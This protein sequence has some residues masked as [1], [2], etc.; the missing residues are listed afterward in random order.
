VTID[1]TTYTLG[2]DP[3]LTA[4]GDNWA[5]TIPSALADGVYEVTV[6]ATDGLGDSISDSSTNEITIDTTGPVAPT[7]NTLITSNN[8]P[9]I[10]GTYDS[11]D[12]GGLTVTLDGVTYVLGVDSELTATGDNWTLAVTAPLADGT[13]EVSVIATDALGNA[14]SDITANEITIDTTGP[15]VPTVSVQITTDNTPTITGTYDSSDA[16]GL[17]VTVGGA[18]YVLGINPELTAAGN[19]WTLTIP[20][21]LADGA[22]DVTAVATDPLGNP[23]TDATSNEVVI[24]TTGP[25]APTVNLQTTNDNTPVISGTFDSG[26]TNNL[27]VTINGVT[28]TLGVDPELT[29][30]GNTWTLTVPTTLAVGT[31]DVVVTAADALGNATTDT[32]AN[33]IV[34]NASGAVVTTPGGN[35]S[36]TGSDGGIIPDELFNADLMPQTLTANNQISMDIN[37][38]NVPGALINAVSGIKNLGSVESITADGKGAVLDAVAAAGA[39][40]IYSGNQLENMLDDQS[41]LWEVYGIKGFSFSFVL[42]ELN[43][44][45]A[46]QESLNLLFA[47]IENK[48][49]LDQLIVKSLMRDK[50]IYLEVDYIINSNPQLVATEILVQQLSGEPLPSWLRI[51]DNG[52]LISGEPPAGMEKIQLRIQ[53]TLNDD[54]VILRYAEVDLKT[55]EIAAVNEVA[56]ELIAG[57]TLFDQQ[58]QKESSKFDDSARI[59]LASLTNNN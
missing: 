31:Y 25:A 10:S 26:D 58:L 27:T 56:E 49:E 6:T 1:G 29:A 3:E 22:Y 45:S 38:A 18:T 54:S 28:Y 23:A 34:I 48:E 44:D 42:T 7:V 21:A 43:H 41:A 35:T 24:D 39:S 17:T 15:A 20:T 30:A 19:N 33:E 37:Q 9:V 16:G 8:T 32:S 5:L 57:T 40:S 36:S 55:G 47:G 51:D 11:G 2:T 13:Y 4:V 46:Q 50:T 12:A 59:L 14:T 52:T 53:V